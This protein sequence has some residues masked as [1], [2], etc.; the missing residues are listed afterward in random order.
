V[1]DEV[2]PVEREDVERARRLVQAARLPAR[3]AVHRAIMRR[4]GIE[5]ILSFDRGFDGVDGITRLG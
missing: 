1:V 3:D 2:Y 5:T 4:R